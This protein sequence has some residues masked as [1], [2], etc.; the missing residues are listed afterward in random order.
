MGS[1]RETT[2]IQEKRGPST[3]DKILMGTAQTL[4]PMAIIA[5]V[6]SWNSSW[7]NA[8]AIATLQTTSKEHS[9]IMNGI[10][11]ALE[12]IAI[13]NERQTVKLN[14]L[15]RDVGECRV[16]LKDMKRSAK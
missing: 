2:E 12:A 14:V 16:D 3:F 6:V 13:I 4:I 15:D 1:Y 10:V 9:Q 7:R 5:G 8:D 11:K